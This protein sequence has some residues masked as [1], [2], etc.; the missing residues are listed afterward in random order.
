MVSRPRAPGILVLRL[1][2]INSILFSFAAKIRIFDIFF[3]K[4]ERLISV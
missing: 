3:V 2:D 4:F 1:M